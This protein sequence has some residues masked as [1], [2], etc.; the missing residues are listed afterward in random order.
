MFLELAP[1]SGTT[2]TWVGKTQDGEKDSGEK[3]HGLT[4]TLVTLMELNHCPGE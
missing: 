3:P 1:S 4:M 2:T